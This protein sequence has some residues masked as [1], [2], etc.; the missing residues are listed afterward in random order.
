MATFKSKNMFLPKF[1]MYTVS[2]FSLSMLIR[3]VFFVDME[4][5][6][7]A[8]VIIF[9]HMFN[10]TNLQTSLCVINW[11]RKCLFGG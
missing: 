4:I 3:F 1:F 9:T 8:N 7:T 2:I 10:T 11:L 5:D 6:D